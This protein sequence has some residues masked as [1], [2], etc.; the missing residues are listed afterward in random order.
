MASATCGKA[1]DA[2]SV[3]IEVLETGV[4]IAADDLS[5][6]YDEFFQVCGPHS[7]AR[8]GHGL[9]L[10]IVQ[11]LVTLLDLKLKVQSEFRRRLAQL[12]PSSP[13]AA[14]TT[15]SGAKPKRRCS[16]LSGAEAPKVTIPMT[17]PAAPT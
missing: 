5:F 16:S 13:F 2:A 17:Q 15:L 10:S 8:E 4:R 12:R 7:P 1:Q 14:A 9:G 11:R 6:I 3:R